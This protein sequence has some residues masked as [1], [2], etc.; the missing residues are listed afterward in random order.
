MVKLRVLGALVVL[1]LTSAL[2]AQVSIIK[3]GKSDYTI[4]T[5]ANASPT[6]KLAAA[7]LSKYLKQMTGTE[8]PVQVGGEITDHSIVVTSDPK[9][10]Q[11]FGNPDREGFS[12]G[13][14][15][16]RVVLL[17][18]SPHATLYA[19]Y[20]FLE[21]QGCRFLAPSFDHY[22][23]HAEVIPHLNEIIVKPMASNPVLAYRKVYV[24]EGHSHNTENLKQLAE[25]MPKLGYNVLVIPTNYQGAGRVKWDNWREA[26]TPELQKRGITIEVGG[27]GY[28]N[29]L[30][31]EMEDGKLFQTH[32][33]YFGQDPK[34][35][36]RSEKGRVF[37]TSNSQAV[38]YLTAKFIEYIKAR[39]EIQ[40]YDFWPPDGAKWCECDKCKALGTPSDRQAILVAH[41]KQ[42]A[43]KV[44]PD[45]RI[46]VLAYHTSVM[47]PENAILD[48]SVFL[49][50]CPIG[51]QFDHQIN[52][53]SSGQNAE[54]VKGLKAWRSK[55]TGDIS[56]YSYYR[57][58]AWNSLPVI[59]PHYLQRDLQFYK[60]IPVQGVSIYGEPG[61][62]YTY[63]LQHYSLAKLAWNPDCDVDALVKDFLEHR[64]GKSAPLAAEAFALLEE[65]EAKFSSIPGT[66]LKSAGE[67]QQAGEKLAAVIDKLTGSEALNKLQSVCL[68]ALGDLELQK[69]RA[70]KADKETIRAKATDL[71]QFLNQHASEGL[72]IMDRM[73]LQKFIAHYAG[74]E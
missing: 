63:E 55:F 33:E 19:V 44:R 57:K 37:C 28:Q 30:N 32:P 51:Q 2:Q 40:I 66:S 56:I 35:A 68:Y 26:V 27:H 9:F 48:K 17:G 4:A 60:K 52:D 16:A 15:D 18:G 61:D 49:D 67:I 11:P 12:I 72:F 7:E 31:A 34:G 13:F 71:H 53:V 54:Y 1:V 42:E 47:P 62:W 45:L 38:D 41:V 69:M 64:Y 21:S 3:D 14:V 65:N 23:G 39:P 43:L 73:P 50:Y 46:E 6:E 74:K 70:D 8:L 59:F 24:E 58:Y 10:V 29:F 36:R 20:Q 22:K 5:N 25:W